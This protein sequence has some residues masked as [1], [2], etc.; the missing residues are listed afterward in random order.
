[1]NRWNT[2]II[3]L[4]LLTSP[5]SSW[6]DGKLAVIVSASS[7]LDSLSKNKVARIFRRKTRIRKSGFSWI[8]TNMPP[9]HPLRQQFSQ[10]L[11]NQ[12]PMEMQDFWNAQYFHG[13]LPPRVVASEEAMLRFVANTPG[14]VG[15]VLSC[16]LDYRVKAVLTLPM[17]GRHC[18]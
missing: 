11:F 3:T 13:I 16:H 7:S 10:L 14:A 2:F 8:P 17:E 6:G 18:K 1:M 15:Y 4:I 9:N 12:S 5:L